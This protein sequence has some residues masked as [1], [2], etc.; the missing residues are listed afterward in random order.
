MT[1]FASSAVATMMPNIPDS[2]MDIHE[3]YHLNGARSMYPSVSVPFDNRLNYHSSIMNLYHQQMHHSPILNGNLP[4]LVPSDITSPSL[5]ALACGI[6]NLNHISMLDSEYQRQVRLQAELYNPATF[7]H[8]PFPAEEFHQHNNATQTRT[9]GD[10][11]IINNSFGKNG[12]KGI[13]NASKCNNIYVDSGPNYPA[14]PQLFSHTQQKSDLSLHHTGNHQD[15]GLSKPKKSKE[16]K[17]M[18]I[19]EEHK[20]TDSKW[21][22]SFEQL[23]QY[24]EMNGHTIVPRGYSL[25]SKLASWVRQ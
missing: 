14:R 24:K 3:R 8:L 20:K 9:T 25:N 18:P 12:E 7:N 16:S 10:I 17:S 13:N 1:H 15:S 23:K 21:H 11:H 2:E 6:P 4:L 19:T 22:A 5:V